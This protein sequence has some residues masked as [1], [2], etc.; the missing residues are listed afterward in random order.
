MKK[1]NLSNK[2]LRNNFKLKE[3]DLIFLQ[4]LLKNRQLPFIFYRSIYSQ[5]IK[6]MPHGS[7]IRNIC[8]ISGNTRSFYTDFKVSRIVLRKLGSQGLIP[9]IQKASW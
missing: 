6:K 1:F 4:L 3:F 9:G 5:K 7:K 8:L 2:Q